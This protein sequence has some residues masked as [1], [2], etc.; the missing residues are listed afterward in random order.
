MKL[1]DFLT[2]INYSKESLFDTE[3]ELVEKEYVPFIINRCLSYFPDTILHANEMN[4]LSHL[5]KRLQFDYLQNS[6]RKRKRY[7]KWLKNEESKDLELIKKNF[8][9]SNQKAKDALS[10]LSEKDIESIKKVDP[11]K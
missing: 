2:A 6:I 11:K 5:E 3:D 10:I 9:Y 4:K 8:G 1:G 7:S